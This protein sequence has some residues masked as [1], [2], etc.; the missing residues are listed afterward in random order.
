MLCVSVC[1][2]VCEGVCVLLLRVSFFHRTKNSE[3][4]VDHFYTGGVYMIRT[5]SYGYMDIRDPEMK[6]IFHVHFLTSSSGYFQFFGKSR[7]E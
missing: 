7:T 2:V 4:E 6:K 5:T 3:G 1:D